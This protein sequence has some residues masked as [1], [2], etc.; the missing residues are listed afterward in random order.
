MQTFSDIMS[1]GCPSDSV[2]YINS[3]F[4]Q[5]NPQMRQSLADNKSVNNIAMITPEMSSSQW[6][7]NPFCSSAPLMTTTI[8]TNT[9]DMTSLLTS[10]FILPNNT[11]NAMSWRPS[12]DSVLGSVA[13][14]NSNA[15]KDVLRFKTCSLFAPKTTAPKMST[16][17]RPLGCRTVFVGGLPENIA[18]DILH[19]VFSLTCG[20][21]SAVR[22]S[23]KKKNFCHI[24]FQN[25]SSVET[26][27]G[28]SGHRLKINDSDD[29]PNTGRL[30]IDYA[31]ARDDQY[32]WEC[33]Q[34]ALQRQMRHKERHEFDRTCPPSPPT[35]HF[36]DDEAI[37]LADKLKGELSFLKGVQV[38]VNWL[39]RGECQK[40]NSGQFYTM[41]QSTNNHI[42]RLQ[43]ERTLFENEWINSRQIYHSKIEA[44]LVQ[45][46]Q[47]EKVFEAAMRQKAWDHF[48][49]AQRKHIDVWFKQIKELKSAHIDHVLNQREED[50]MDLSDGDDD[51]NPL[52]YGNN[53]SIAEPN[54]SVMSL[55]DENDALLCQ[56]ESF[57]NEA[58]FVEEE[59]RQ[60]RE[61]L[62]KQVSL[63]QQALQGMQHQLI[64]LTRN[65][66]ED[67]LPSND[68]NACS[69]N[70]EM[71]SNNNTFGAISS[72]KTALLISL[73]SI[74][75]NVHPYGTTS[76]DISSYLSQQSHIRETQLLSTAFIH[77]FLSQYPQLFT[78]LESDSNGRTLWR[79]SGFRT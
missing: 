7:L 32:D 14:N 10:N 65:K 5:N 45:L 75:L 49:K 64:A 42:K 78:Q 35:V 72:E 79:F 31:Q 66:P 1:F 15:N 9:P 60:E 61:R 19:E 67:C 28:L 18:E 76:E 77:S 11:T 59:S 52:I 71:S 21:I 51:H 4:N 27:I 37:Q 20:D 41:I 53:T 17:E 22:M 33:R 36:S 54:N 70:R 62:E 25:E 13:V 58:V 56:V 26:A 73:I 24:R 69:D 39:E 6:I 23:K 29:S 3:S 16:R 48:T 50:E 47:I 74:Y 34:R 68:C 2:P 8:A 38:L 12:L 57:R 46:T 40:R 44:I 63:L 55:R 30:H 43:N